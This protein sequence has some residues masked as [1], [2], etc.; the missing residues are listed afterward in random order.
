MVNNF[1]TGQNHNNGNQEHKEENSDNVLSQ[2]RQPQVFFQQYDPLQTTQLQHSSQPQQHPFTYHQQFLAT[3]NQQPQLQPHNN[4]NNNVLI[5]QHQY[6]QQPILYPNDNLSSNV[7]NVPQ[8]NRMINKNFFGCTSV[9]QQQQLLLQAYLLQQQHQNALHNAGMYSLKH[10]TAI[11]IPSHCVNNSFQQQS[12]YVPPLVTAQQVTI[13]RAFPL[14]VQDRPLIAPIYNGVNTSYP[15]LR[16]LNVS[17]PVY[18]VD[19]FI[20]SSECSFLINTASDSFT[21]A[22]VVGPGLGGISKSR[23]SST[24]YLA[25]EDLPLLLQKVYALTGKPWKHTELPQVGRYLPNQQ[26]LQH[27]DAFD[28]SNEDG[29]RFASNGGQRVVTVLIYLN[30]VDRGGHTFFPMLDI[31]VQ[32][33]MGMALVFFPS[34]VDG[35]LD[36]QALHAALPAVDVKFVSQIWIRQGNYEGFPSKRLNQIMV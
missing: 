17:P 18:T 4:L 23:T 29:Q 32:P 6:N 13:P 16:L 7:A 33:K 3:A 10:P 27:Y 22:P 2:S 11:N 5:Q 28:L 9:D 24:C 34:T 35:L 30:D 26:Y 21:P 31:K 12:Q 36:E 15:G 20:T 1:N 25:R 14:K 19:N 8:F